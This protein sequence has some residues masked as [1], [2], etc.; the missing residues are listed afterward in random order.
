[1]IKQTW[2]VRREKPSDLACTL[3]RDLFDMGSEPSRGEL[4]IVHRIAFKAGDYPDNETELGGLCED[5]LARRIDAS[6]KAA[7]RGLDRG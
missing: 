2:G 4:G 1:M 6:L 3:A 5:A 7:D